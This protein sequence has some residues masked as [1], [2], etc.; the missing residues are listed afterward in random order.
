MNNQVSLSVVRPNSFIGSAVKI[1]I[2]IDNY[3]YQLANDKTLTFNLV[4][5][6]HVITYKVWCRRLKTVEIDAVAG[7]SYSIIF[8][9]DLLWGGFKLSKDSILN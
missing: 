8:K 3:P 1:D 2:T 4:P 7:K 5:G 9:P 6:H